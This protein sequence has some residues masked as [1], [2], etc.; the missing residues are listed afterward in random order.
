[1]LFGRVTDR[2]VR[3]QLRTPPSDEWDDGNLSEDFRALD[4]LITRDFPESIPA[5]FKN[6]LQNPEESQTGVD[7]DLYMVYLTPHACVSAGFTSI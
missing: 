4:K 3:H 1:M 6:Y 2:N 7:T 5:N